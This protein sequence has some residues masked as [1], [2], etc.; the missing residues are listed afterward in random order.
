MKTSNELLFYVFE[1]TREVRGGVLCLVDLNGDAWDLVRS[2][3]YY[4]WKIIY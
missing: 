2:Q 3:I 4:S 1:N